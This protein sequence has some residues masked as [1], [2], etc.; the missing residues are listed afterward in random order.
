M[1][2]WIRIADRGGLPYSK[3]LL[4]NS[5]MSIGIDPVMA[6]GVAERL[7]QDL[8]E[9]G[10]A[11]ITRKD[12]RTQTQRLLAEMLGSQ[13]A[14]DYERWQKFRELDKPLVVLIGGA[15]GT[16]KSTVATQVAARLGINRVISTDTIREVMRAF[17]SEQLMPALHKSSFEAGQTITR[18]LAENFDPVIVGFEE[19]LQGVAT[20]LRAVVGRCVH[21]GISVI[22]EG[23]HVVPGYLAREFEPHSIFVPVVLQVADEQTH[24]SHFEMRGSSAENRSGER[25]IN[26]FEAIRSIHDHIVSLAHK[27]G[28]PVIDAYDLDTM[29]Q[30]VIDLIIHE[31]GVQSAR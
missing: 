1:N 26:K 18:P 22:I 24:R 5:L 21:E 25:Y 20:A 15:T 16:G 9:S 2:E 12:L 31:A 28:V 4:A 17:F 10:V 11:E 19:Q 7:E 6:F 23:A 27:R 13:A 8:R 29:V 30:S 14:S 3:G